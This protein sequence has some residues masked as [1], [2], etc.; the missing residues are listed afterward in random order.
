MDSWKYFQVHVNLMSLSADDTVFPLFR[1]LMLRHEPEWWMLWHSWFLVGNSST[2]NLFE[3]YREPSLSCMYL[4]EA[5]FYYKS[6]KINLGRLKQKNPVSH[7]PLH[8]TRCFC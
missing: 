3:D 8:S 2:I 1:F 5:G 7:S 6:G 4:E